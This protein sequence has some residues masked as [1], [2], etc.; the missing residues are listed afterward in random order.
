MSMW[1]LVILVALLLFW[2]VGAYNRLIRLRSAALQ[3]FG[4]LDAHWQRWLTL[5]AEYA[6]ARAG[7]TEADAPASAATEAASDTHAA[8]GAAAAQFG[9][10]LAVARARPLDGGAAAALAA[11][12]QVLDTAWH[13]M[14]HDAARASE[15]VAPP[16]LAPW[17]HQREQLAVH[18]GEARRLFNEAVTVYNRAIVQFPANVLAW[19]FGMKQGSAL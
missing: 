2:G 9:A 6:Q 4:A 14:I 1:I 8:L 17:I 7:Q 19:L 5:L 12:A 16:A 11:A 13:G 15:G 3:A 10:S 18:S